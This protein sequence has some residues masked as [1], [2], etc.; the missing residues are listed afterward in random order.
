VINGDELINEQA[1][2]IRLV[3]TQVH[4]GT[5]WSLSF[6]EFWAEGAAPPPSCRLRALNAL[7]NAEVNPDYRVGKAID[8]ATNTQWI[9]TTNGTSPDNNNAWYQIDL[10]SR[11]QIDRVKWIGA[12]GTPFYASSPT[13]YSIAV[14]DDENSWTPVL[15]RV[16]AGPV[17]NGSESMSAQGRYVRITTTKVFDGTGWSL[18]F[19]EFWVE[20]SDVSNLLAA[21]VTPSADV[22]G[23]PA[24]NAIDN[25]RGTQWV[26]SLEPSLQ[27]NIAWLK[28]DFG[29]RKQLNRVRWIGATASPYPPA[30]SPTDYS[31]QV[32]DD[33]ANWQTILTRNNT[34]RVAN[35]DE[36][37]NEQA[38]FLK[39]ATTQV[40]DGTGW[41]LS[42]FEFWVEGY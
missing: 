40:D 37:I 8:L 7:A 38:R 41:S 4:D 31:I 30:S 9:A 11:K 16:N 18:S 39:L 32:S 26:A 10:G 2:Y 35:G 5:G 27:N 34:V 29:S 36:L 22:P 13:D 15:S 14:S 3:T 6:F 24:T 12:T 17:F 33:D 28:L 1:R 21:K 19:H 20:G 42:F 25:S 23:Y